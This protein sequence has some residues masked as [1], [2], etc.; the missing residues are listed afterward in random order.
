MLTLAP[1]AQAVTAGE[2]QR[3]T[4]I[5]DADDDANIDALL[6]AAQGV[7]ETATRRPMLPRAV[8]IQTRAGFGLRWFVPVAPASGL[9]AIDWQDATGAWVAL[10]LDGIRLEM[11]HDEPQVVFPSGFFDAVDDGAPLRLSM[12]VGAAADAMPPQLKQAVILLA[13]DWF[14]AG[15]AVEEKQFLNVSFGCKAIMRQVR[16]ARPTEWCA[17]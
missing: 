5:L 15:I 6:F 1:I 3:Q 8:Q 9:T 12:T 16:Y 11:A 13:K 14:E 4:H 10:S 7:V 17:T 2:F